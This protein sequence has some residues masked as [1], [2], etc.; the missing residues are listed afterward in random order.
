MTTPTTVSRAEWA[1]PNR[2]TPLGSAAYYAV[3]F[4]PAQ[5]RDLYAMLLAWHDLIHAIARAPA[6]PGVAR[7][8]LDWWRTELSQVLG[9]GAPRHPLMTGLQ[10][11]G[12]NET[13]A[14]PMLAL[15]DA[16]E[17]RIRQPRLADGAAFAE[18][19]RRSGGSL[20]VLLCQPGQ[21]SA[22][23]PERCA[24]LG[25]YWDAVERIRRLPSEP[26]LSPA[27]LQPSAADAVDADRREALCEQLLAYPGTGRDL[28]N[29]PVPDVVRRLVAGAQAT[30]RQLA[31]RRYKA[32]MRTIDRA[33]IA[34]LWTAWR[35]RPSL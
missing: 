18:A 26:G 12:L 11:E 6:D 23:N 33:P 13:A 24:A 32:A 7:L 35:C 4:A 21:P 1:F 8:K 2:V 28:R 14:G 27:G 3:R 22:Y 17:R 25:A 30:H 29:E 16:S 15:V 9:G 20:F 5:R 34:N 19:C 10:A 31:K